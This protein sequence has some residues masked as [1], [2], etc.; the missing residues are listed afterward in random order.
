MQFLDDGVAWG[1]AYSFTWSVSTWYWFKLRQQNGVLSGKVW[2]DGTAEP[3][4]WAYQQTGWASRSGAPGL[5]GG[6]SFAGSSATASFDDVSVTT[7]GT[8]SVVRRSRRGQWRR[9]EKG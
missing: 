8:V 3:T 4:T 9:D 7:V 2:A 5:D 1:N 6:A